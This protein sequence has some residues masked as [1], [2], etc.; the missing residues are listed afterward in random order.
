MTPSSGPCAAMSERGY[1]L[2]SVL[3][4]VAGASALGF[5]LSGTAREAAATSQTRVALARAEWAADGCLAQARA[6]LVAALEAENVR[7]LR[8]DRVAWNTV[9][10]VIAKE[11]MPGCTVTA[12]AVG[13]RV[14]IN[15]QDQV[16]LRDIFRGAGVDEAEADS[17]AAAVIDWRDPDSVAG[18]GGAEAGWYVERSSLPPTNRPFASVDELRQVRGMA[19]LDWLDDVF[20]VEPGPLSINHASPRVLALLPG[21]S[22][23]VIANTLRA[24]QRGTPIGAFTELAARLNSEEQEG[25]TR[26]LPHLVQVAVLIPGTWVL[27]ASTADSNSNAQVSVAIWL[28]RAGIGTAV[29]RRT[30]RVR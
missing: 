9:D 6:R 22:G 3:W 10:R 13:S 26:A 2:I 5:A 23:A 27:E 7:W 15:A 29:D 18:P 17:L 21:F 12:R 14:D 28:R 11:P 24:R 8:S 4:M 25:V 30:V 19:A 16:G 1:A 20:D